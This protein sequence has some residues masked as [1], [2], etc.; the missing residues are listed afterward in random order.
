MRAA[1]IPLTAGTKV[2][3]GDG[4]FTILDWALIDGDLVCKVERGEDREWMPYDELVSTCQQYLPKVEES[5]TFDFTR[6]NR[7]PYLDDVE[8]ANLKREVADLLEV[9]HGDRGGMVD[10]P[11]SGHKP[12][13]EFDPSLTTLRARID[14]KVKELQNKGIATSRATL[15]RK[16]R[17]LQSEGM[18]GLIHKSKMATLNV[19]D[20]VDKQAQDIARDLALEL[21]M[22]SKCTV[23][24][25]NRLILFRARLQ[26]EGVEYTNWSKA[27]LSKVIELEA[28]KVGITKPAAVRLS[29]SSR[30]RGMHGRYVVSHPNELVQ[31]DV[32]SLDVKAWSPISGWC[33]VDAI[34]AIDAYDR[35]VRVCKLVPAPHTARDIAIAIAYMLLPGVT[36][37]PK[38]VGDH[39]WPG[40]PEQVEIPPDLTP[41]TMAGTP[42]KGRTVEMLVMDH[43]S[44]FDSMLVSAAAT[45]AG[46][47]VLYAAPRR[48]HHKAMIES[49][50]NQ[51]AQWAQQFPGAKGNNVRNRG[52]N[53]EK[54]ALFTIAELEAALNQR[55]EQVYHRSPH[56][57]LRDPADPNRRI[58]PNEAY[59][60]FVANGGSPN[61]LARPGCA[62][63]FLPSELCRADDDGIELNAVRYDGPGLTGLRDRDRGPKSPALRVAYDPHD[64]TRIW[65]EDGDHQWRT[66]RDYG[67]QIGARVPM[68]VSRA[69]AVGLDLAG[70]TLAIDEQEAAEAKP[71]AQER[72]KLP[73]QVTRKL[74]VT[75]ERMLASERDRYA[76]GIALLAPD[77]KPG[78]DGWEQPKYVNHNLDDKPISDRSDL[79]RTDVASAGGVFSW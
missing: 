11:R 10:C 61:V 32:A 68:Q 3:D 22:D 55:I 7:F 66:V 57:G 69:T 33:S 9:I 78:A 62:F 40:A 27:A 64:P 43:G 31:I 73:Q 4:S 15:Y 37:I 17:K 49:F 14:S 19:I 76:L 38:G 79:W 48:G 12:L 36:D 30:P 1:Q 67:T 24:Q 53:P 20:D 74:A 59:A 25:K 60:L 52:K 5:A 70:L 44:Q 21:S 46:I 28:A 54:D 56:D 71:A 75:F 47:N 72:K 77:P 34:T 63:D 16:V 45:R 35:R 13:E 8:R 18:E 50:H 65:V 42:V 51:L 29:Q 39:W 2:V 26:A 23:S 6:D 41:T 58:S